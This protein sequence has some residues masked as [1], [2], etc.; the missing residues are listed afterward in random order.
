M[1]TTAS[2]IITT[3]FN[4]LNVYMPGDSIPA[5]DSSLALTLLN[6]MMGQWALQTGTIPVEARETFALTAGKGGPGNV[7]TLGSGGNLDTARI[8]SAAHLTRAGLLLGGS[9]PAVEIPRTVYTDETYAAIRVKDLTTALFTGVYY[10]PT[11]ASGFGSVSLWP[12]PNTA[13]HQ[14]VLYRLQQLNQ[15]VSLTASY[16]L[17][18]GYDEAIWTNLTLRLAMPFGRKVPDDLREL[19]RSSLGVIKGSNLKMVDLPIDP[20]FLTDRSRRAYNIDTNRS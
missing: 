13:L 18:L 7:Y 1:A 20:M 6:G 9:T 11:F 10:N 2:T 12:V 16:D 5:A 3:A 19:A 4:N 8:P 17:S 15:F 14:L